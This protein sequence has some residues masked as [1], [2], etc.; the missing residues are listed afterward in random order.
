MGFPIPY[1]YVADVSDSDE[2]LDGR[3][4]IIDGS[5]RIRALF[6]FVTNEVE[7]TDLKELKG[8]EGFKFEDL[9]SGRQRRFLRESLRFVE[10]KGDVEESHRRDLFERINSGVKEL[11][12]A[13]SRHGAEYANS[14]Y[15]REVIDVCAANSLFMKLAPLS[16]KKRANGD[17]RELVTRFF[18]FYHD[19]DSYAGNLSD[20]LEDY[21]IKVKGESQE[22]I[23]SDVLLFN[24][25]MC[26]IDANFDFGFRRTATSKT[27]TRTRFDSLAIGAA[28]ALQESK[29]LT[30]S[31]TPVSE[32]AFSEEFL[33]VINS[34]A[35]NNKSN[36]TNRI[37]YAKNR[38]LGE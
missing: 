16:D 30:E 5:Q 13:E 31:I 21:L 36:V 10:L 3:I 34:D 1:I 8:L 11:V 15:Y 33:K 22:R 38:F 9:S 35:A 27:T 7:L 37:E 24:N 18:A 19:F 25:V 12:G 20:F 29:E 23:K 28:K 32:W 26:F 2:E 14:E 17:H 6:Y 4:E